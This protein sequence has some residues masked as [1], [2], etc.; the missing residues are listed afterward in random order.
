MH[1]ILLLLILLLLLQLLLLLA[2]LSHALHSVLVLP[3]S[4]L[5]SCALGLDSP[6]GAATTL[7]AVADILDAPTES[8]AA[9]TAKAVT[10]AAGSTV[11][12]AVI[13]AVIWVLVVLAL[14]FVNGFESVEEF[15]VGA[16]EE[17]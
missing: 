14:E 8:T 13:A 12:G 9:T 15:V 5:L 1:V 6:S 4:L 10:A 7:V 2:L 16:V 11:T 3:L 17:E